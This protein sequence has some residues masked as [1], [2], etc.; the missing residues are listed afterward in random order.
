MRVDFMRKLSL[1]AQFSFEN[2]LVA[3]QLNNLG[4]GG[5]DNMVL[6]D[7]VE[8]RHWRQPGDK[9]LYSKFSMINDGGFYGSDAYYANGS[10]LSLDNLSLSYLLPEKW[11]ERIRMKQGMISVNSSKIFKLTHYRV[12]DVELGNVPQIRRIAAN[13]RFSF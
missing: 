12:A 7:E 9:A 6:Y 11:L 5:L 1:D 10:F 2:N 13:V 3:D 8:N 4:Y